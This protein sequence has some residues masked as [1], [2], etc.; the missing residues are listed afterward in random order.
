MTVQPSP[1]AFAA[2]L[3]RGAP[4]PS[5]R[6]EGWRWSDLQRVMKSLPP[7][8]PPM[9]LAPG[10]GPFHGLAAERGLFVNGRGPGTLTLS[11]T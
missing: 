11:A 6:D 1:L 2:G 4:F 9:A 7:E 5:R 3:T 10:Q 8:S